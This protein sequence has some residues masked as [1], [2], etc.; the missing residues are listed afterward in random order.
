MR[1]NSY[2]FAVYLGKFPNVG[3]TSGQDDHEY[4]SGHSMFIFAPAAE[5]RFVTTESQQQ[6]SLLTLPRGF[7]RFGKHIHHLGQIFHISTVKFTSEIN[8]MLSLNDISS[9]IQYD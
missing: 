4:C 9:S 5:K 2:K 3:S 6:T 7:W 8:N 1:R